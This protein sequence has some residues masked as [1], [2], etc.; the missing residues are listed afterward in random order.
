MTDTRL[1][2][3]VGHNDLEETVVTFISDIDFAPLMDSFE[4][5]N[6]VRFV[7]HWPK[8]GMIQLTVTMPFDYVRK[9]LDEIFEQLTQTKP[10]YY[11]EI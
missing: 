5:I 1:V 4:R 2:G 9:E 8:R 10:K 7:L 6:H 3:F 11:K